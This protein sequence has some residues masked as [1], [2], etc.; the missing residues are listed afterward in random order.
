MV[1]VSRSAI[2][3]PRHHD[4]G[5]QAL[6]LL[7]DAIRQSSDQG[8]IA[9][10]VAELSVGEGEEHRLLRAERRRGAARLLDAGFDEGVADGA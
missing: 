1:R 10:L 3:A 8:T 4:V 6:D 9:E 2:G 7:R 5:V